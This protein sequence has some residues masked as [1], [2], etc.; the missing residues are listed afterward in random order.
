MRAWIKIEE[1][2]YNLSLIN[3]NKS[4]LHVIYAQ[5]DYYKNVVLNNRKCQRELFSKSKDG[6]LLPADV[7]TAKLKNVINFSVIP[8]DK[9][10]FN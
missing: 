1:V 10:L 9:N 6:V 8:D 7:M 3:D 2:D 4:K 5:L